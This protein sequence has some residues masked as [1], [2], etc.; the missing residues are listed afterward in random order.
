[1][2]QAQLNPAEISDLIRGRIESLDVSAQP[3]NEGTIVSVSDGIVRVHGLAD[4]QYG[5]MIE[6]VGGAGGALTGMALNLERDSVGLRGARRLSRPLRRHDRAL[7]QAHPRSTGRPRAIGPGSGRPRQSIDG[8]GPLNASAT[9]PVEKVAPGVIARQTVDQPVQMGIKCID[10]MVPIG[11]GQRELI[12]GDRQIGKTAIAVDAVINQK[13]TGIKCVYVAIGQ[14]MSTIANIVRTFEE[15]GAMEHT[16]VVAASAADPAR[17]STSRRTPGARWASSSATAAKTRSS[18]T[19]TSPNRR[20]HTARFPCCCAG[21]R[22]AKPIR[23]TCSI[24]TRGCSN[25]RRA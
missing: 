17:C 20:G 19:T 4:A 9:S 14:K 6:F 23:A 3:A 18:F 24:C 5:E 13:G 2:Q 7:H 11:R 15:N 22:V 16:I 21:R 10:A 8:K 12:I 1:M 25:A